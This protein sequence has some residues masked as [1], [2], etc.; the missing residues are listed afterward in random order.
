MRPSLH[1]YALV[2]SLENHFIIVCAFPHPEVTFERS[3]FKGTGVIVKRVESESTNFVDDKFHFLFIQSWCQ[4]QMIFRRIYRTR[5]HFHSRSKSSRSLTFINFEPG[6]DSKINLLLISSLI[7]S[8]ARSTSIFPFLLI[9]N[10][11]MYF[12][13]T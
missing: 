2:T 12:F 9:I 3:G 4:F 6:E 5:L 13:S 7:I 11:P 1:P 10:S 8:I